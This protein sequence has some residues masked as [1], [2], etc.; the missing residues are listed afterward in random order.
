MPHDAAADRTIG[1]APF[2]SGQEAGPVEA[3]PYD[4]VTPL[5]NFE[6]SPLASV[7]VAVMSGFVPVTVVVT[8]KVK[9]CTPVLV[10][11]T[12]SEPR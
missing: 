2:L 4:T 12:V 1:P 7:S 11:V 10:G 3:D 6:V 5:E 9:F 8:V